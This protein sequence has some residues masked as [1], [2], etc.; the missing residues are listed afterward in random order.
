[1]NELEKRSFYSFLG[2]YIISSFL[3]IA[4]AGFW[5]Y[6]SQKHTL[7]NNE[8]YRLEHIADRIGT[9]IIMAHMHG[10]PL[11]MPDLYR[12]YVSVALI[13]TDGRLSS[14]TMPVPVP[15]DRTD[16]LEK[17]GY[18][19]LISD[20]PKEHMDIRYVVVTSNVLSGTLQ[21][22]RKVVLAMMAAIALLS[23]TVAWTLSR[24][25][26]R[27][28]HQ[29]I[30]QTERF[31]NDVTHELN[32]PIT[33]LSMT[34]EQVLSSG[35]CSEKNLRNLSVST[36]QLYDI[37]RSLTY[38]NFARKKEVPVPINLEKIATMSAA[39][40][41][42]LLESKG[43]QLQ[44]HTEPFHFAM[45]EQEAQLLLGNLIGNAIKYSP[46]G[47][48]VTL[49][50]KEQCIEVKD[51][52]IGIAPALQKQIFEPYVRGT[53]QGGGFGVG[54]S[55]VTRICSEYGIALSLDSAPGK[56]SSFRLCFP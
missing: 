22:L 6:T 37:Y 19:I 34:A 52:G 17:D 51:E 49:S 23:A 5:Y 32:T 46:S 10:S 36:R 39:Y 44:L 7:E 1:M 41:R 28:L 40:Y 47:G 56:G 29:R 55:I 27:P 20:A 45:P 48:T 53:E 15:T 50:V 13:G 31:V 38:L 24:L 26:M 30:V 11:Q 2:L 16:Y 42:P 35:G 54:L 3:F 14:G 12:T 25:F 33:A 18:M 9:A 4:L 8:H 43:L 21:Q